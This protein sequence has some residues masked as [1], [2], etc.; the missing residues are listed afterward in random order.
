[1]T[2]ASKVYLEDEDDAAINVVVMDA[3]D[4]ND[5]LHLRATDRKTP[6]RI[7]NSGILISE[8]FC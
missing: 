2:Y 5:M 4:G 7:R 1:M 8:K 6:L 3:R